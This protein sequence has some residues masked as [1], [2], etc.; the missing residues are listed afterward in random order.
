[1]KT[2]KVTRIEKKYKDK[3]TGEYKNIVINYSKVVDRLKEFRKD[4]PR[5]LIET[6]PTIKDGQIMFKARVLKDKAEP[7]SSEAT[8]HAIG[9][10]GD[11]K[12]FE[13]LETIAVGR[14]LALLGYSSDG[15][16]VSSE[17]MEAFEEYKANQMKEEKEI[18]IERLEAC[19]T[20]E[21]LKNVYTRLSPRLI[22][23]LSEKKDEMKAIIQD[24][25][26]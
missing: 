21:E 24:A 14:A 16:I 2:T 13:K 7:S 18:A 8:G 11:E 4:N 26:K 22:K 15:E 3:K 25:K 23:E 19:T 17:E 1:M 20:L 6:T 10:H 5:S 12:A 9:T